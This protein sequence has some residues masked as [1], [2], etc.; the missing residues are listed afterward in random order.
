MMISICINPVV[1]QDQEEEE[2]LRDTI[3]SEIL[4][5]GTTTMDLH[6]I[7][8]CVRAAQERGSMITT[9]HIMVAHHPK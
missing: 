2:L 5:I 4:M 3:C 6:Q 9:I 7:M 1:V 8:A